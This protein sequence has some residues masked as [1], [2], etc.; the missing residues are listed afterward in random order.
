MEL[1]VRVVQQAHCALLSRPHAPRTQF[2][3][4]AEIK[5]VARNICV[6]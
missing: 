4:S 6:L 1:C 2:D 5:L 3:I